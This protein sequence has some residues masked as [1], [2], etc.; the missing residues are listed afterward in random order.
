MQLYLSGKNSF[1][2][3][4][5]QA[6]SFICSVL[7][8]SPYHQVY[9]SPGLIPVPSLH[10]LGIHMH[11]EC[12]LRSSSHCNTCRRDDSPPR[13]RKHTVCHWNCISVECVQR[14]AHQTPEEC[15][16]R[17]PA[18]RRLPPHEVCEATGTPSPTN[19][20]IFARP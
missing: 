9:I 18:V 3:F 20:R 4:K 16:M 7:P 5:S 12:M 17:D 15:H 2:N 8:D 14:R 1:K 13:R 11:R 10:V 19:I 6:D